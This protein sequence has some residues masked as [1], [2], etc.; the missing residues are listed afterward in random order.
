LISSGA[1][2]RFT[3]VRAEGTDFWQPAEKFEEFRD[4]LAHLAELE[5]LSGPGNESPS[6]GAPA[7]VIEVAASVTPE[8][9]STTAAGAA[10]REAPE[11]PLES[12]VDPAPPT[13]EPPPPG[14]GDRFFMVGGDGREYG[15]VSEAQLREWIAQR[16]ANA[17][18]RIRREEQK[19]FTP[20]GAWPGF[21][22]PPGD[23]GGPSSAAP[24]TLDSAQADQL[25]A[26][27]IG[28]GYNLAVGRCFARSWKL[29]RANFWL[30]TGTT[31]V[32]LIL[33][34]ILHSVP[35]VGNVAA[36]ALGGVL[37]AGLSVLFLK[38]I[39]G[40]RAEFADVFVGFQRRFVPLMLA[41]AI[42]FILIS[43]GLLLC[44]LPGIY[45]AVGWLFAYPLIIERSLDFWPAMELSRKV[46]HERWWELFALALVAVGLFVGSILLTIF[47]FG[48]GMFFAA[49]IAFGA[50]MYAYEDIFGERREREA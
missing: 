37:S 38:L 33:H 42:T 46:V 3:L 1:V 28:R 20:L 50:L 40:Q 27:I 19:E 41:S 16:R 47:V 7:P 9:P 17:A 21:A 23:S 11:R 14:A 15:P 24:P 45:L 25:A 4:L 5:V 22:P 10:T 44:L 49:P 8:P 35:V 31:A 48:V 13:D 32:V 34:S 36:V 43:A 26:E 39:R 2:D 6:P 29:Y 12:P 18:T 30:L